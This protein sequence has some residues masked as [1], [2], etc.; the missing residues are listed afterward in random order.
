LIVFFNCA[1]IP[2][3]K[4]RFY[5]YVTLVIQYRLWRR[6]LTKMSDEMKEV[7]AGN[8]AM[9]I[10]PNCP[11]GRLY[12]VR[13]GDSMFFIA[14]RFNISLQSLIQ[15]NPQIA[16]PNLIY[17]GQILCVPTGGPGPGM[18]PQGQMYRVQ[19][20]DT[21]FE[22]ARR[23]NISLTALIAANPQIS[24]P[25]LIFPGQ[26]LCIPVSGAIAMPLPKP[27]VLPEP[28]VMLPPEMPMPY[29]PIAPCPPE[30]PPMPCPPEMPP[31]P[32]PPV[33]P[34]L[35]PLPTPIAP[36]PTQPPCQYPMPVYVVVPWEECPYRPKKKKCTH[37]KHKR[38]R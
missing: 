31:M 28:P 15:A 5:E 24:N 4:D 35:R 29:P 21:M 23:N 2:V 33:A 18:C 1:K 36:G 26:L 14:K 25:D 20:G 7:T 9:L 13:A 17:P 3:T 27:P 22:I 16:D 12:T 30:M 8:E 6:Y 34:Y 11:G 19:A 37:H 38:C 32:C 10:A